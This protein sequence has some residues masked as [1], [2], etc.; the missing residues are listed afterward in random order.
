MNSPQ[1]KHPLLWVPTGYF[2]MALT[3]NILTAAAVIMFSNLGMSNTEAAGYA[4]ALGLAYTIKPLFAA[5]MEMYKTKKFFV[6]VSQVIQGIG[7]IGVALILNLPSFFLPMIILFWVLSFV[8]SV[9][10]ITSDGVYVTSLDGKQQAQ[11]CGVQSLSWNLGKLAIT[12]GLVILTGFLHQN[13]F[14]YDPQATGSE[15]TKSWQIAFIVLGVI[16]L[17]MAA[18]HW[19]FMP[20]GSRT[21]NAPDTVAKAGSML[22]DAFVTFFQKKDIWLMIGFAFLFRLSYGFLLAPSM[23]FM[24]DASENGGLALSNQEMG[25]IYSVFGLIAMIIGSL[26][27]GFYVAQKGLQKTLFP[28]CCAINIPNITFLV[29]SIYQPESYV[30]I[31][32]GVIVEQFFFGIGSVG[33]MIYLMQ[34]MAPG[35][36]ATSHYAFGT[37]LM[38]LCMMLTGMISGYLQEKMGYMGYFIFV[39]IATIPSFLICWFAP[40][41][42][43]HD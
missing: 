36:Y 43:K 2:T 35:K 20:D 21:E 19:K 28:L 12:G 41:N 11:F 4:S 31:A 6:L 23:L 42:Q 30:L 16:M 39:M 14:G 25:L 40:F 34:Q 37:A 17:A 8:G 32:S 1:I 29:L 26:I 7:F 10:D 22:L 24:K 13:I 3:Y 5:F 38:G 15:W 33:F 27:G 18:W 9:Q